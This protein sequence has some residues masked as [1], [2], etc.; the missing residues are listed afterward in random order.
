MNSAGQG[1]AVIIPGAHD[2]PRMRGGPPVKADK[3]PAVVGQNGSTLGYCESQDT[4]IRNSLPG[5]AGLL[6]RQNIMAEQPELCDH[7]VIEVF[8]SIQPGHAASR[9][10]IRLDGPFN[11]FSVASIIFPGSLKVRVAE[12]RMM[13]QNAF[14]GQTDLFPFDQ[15]VDGV[16]R[17]ADTGISAADVGVLFN[18]TRVD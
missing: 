12:V 8:I 7:G 3:V 13:L 4:R 14:I 18:P 16:P 1:H 5:L 9:F 10:C 17:I 6:G 11:L 15:A 2:D